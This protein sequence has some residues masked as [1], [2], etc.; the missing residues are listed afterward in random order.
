[1]RGMA[2]GKHYEFAMKAVLNAVSPILSKKELLRAAE[3][4]MST[5]TIYGG[6]GNPKMAYKPTRDEQFILK[7]FGA[8][9]ELSS[10]YDALQD[11]AEYIR[12]FPRIKGLSKVRWLQ[13]QV[14]LYR[15]ELYILCERMESFW[16]IV[17]KMYRTN[18]SQKQRSRDIAQVK[19]WAQINLD[20]VLP[21]RVRHDHVH[22][23]RQKDPDLSELSSLEFLL[24]RIPE[25]KEPY[26][27]FIRDAR[28]K[29]RNTF[30]DGNKHIA[31]ILNSYFESLNKIILDKNNKL[32]YSV[33]I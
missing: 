24:P 8:F 19:K 22:V 9:T 14:M 2:N 20:E 32:I 27:L 12:Q 29:W 6:D 4:N 11:I 28:A 3:I 13:H 21:I 23:E 10:T 5:M 33:V 17:L 31:E 18:P 1:M 15:E 26:N 25:L 16:S 7:L 30:L